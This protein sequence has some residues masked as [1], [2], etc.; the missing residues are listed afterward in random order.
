MYNGR[1]TDR[2]RVET[3][4]SNKFR[5]RIIGKKSEI[6][7]INY[8]LQPTENSRLANGIG[9]SYCNYTSYQIMKMI[10]QKKINAQY[11]FLHIPKSFKK[12]KTVKEIKQMLNQVQHDK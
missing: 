4:C 5:N 3:H 10:E 8:F 12:E 1:D 7:K 6:L 2:I 11:T 9:N